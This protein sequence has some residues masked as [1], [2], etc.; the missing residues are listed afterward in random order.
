MAF[1]DFIKNR[2][3]KGQQADAPKPQQPKPETAKQMYTREAAQP[4]RQN[5]L[6][7]ISPERFLQVNEIRAR[8]Q[9]ATQYAGQESPAR[10]AS[11]ADAPVS[12]EAMRQN[13]TGQDKT[14]PALS[15]TSAQTGMTSVESGSSL[16]PA[17]TPKV[18]QKSTPRPQQTV[19]R[20]PPSWER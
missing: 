2:M 6:N 13:M 12:Q 19:A 3:A 18:Q 1:L 8:L 5:T 9:K 17:P 16:R 10:Q 14:T 4:P 7:Q 11:P 20:R 15:P